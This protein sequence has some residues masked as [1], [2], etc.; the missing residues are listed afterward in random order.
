MQLEHEEMIIW[1][2]FPT[3]DFLTADFPGTL[4]AA[5]MLAFPDFLG[6]LLTEPPLIV[7]ILGTL[8]SPMGPSE[9]TDAPAFI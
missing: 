2:L 5:I 6:F 7:R 4:R 8:I 1:A 3:A 9:M